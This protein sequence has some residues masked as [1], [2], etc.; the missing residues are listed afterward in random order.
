MLIMLQTLVVRA[1]QYDCTAKGQ[2]SAAAAA[3]VEEQQQLF[4]VSKALATPLAS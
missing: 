3:E 2:I 4:L 1:L